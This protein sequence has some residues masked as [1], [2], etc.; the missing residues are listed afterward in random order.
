[1]VDVVDFQSNH[2][3]ARFK[4]DTAI[5]LPKK[6]FDK[7]GPTD[8]TNDIPEKSFWLRVL[9]VGN[10]ESRIGKLLWAFPDTSSMI[11]RTQLEAGFAGVEGGVEVDMS[12]NLALLAV[13]E[14]S[15]WT[16]LRSNATIITLKS[17]IVHPFL[18]VSSNG[19]IAST[20]MTSGSP[21]CSNYLF[22]TLT[23]ARNELDFC[24]KASR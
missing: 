17:A 12:L 15:W 3:R 4:R 22:Q 13:C 16:L 10:S 7:L 6:V 18:P 11:D 23:V 5:W 9:L 1:M 2:R 8:K 20:R 14:W 19:R 24:S 21:I